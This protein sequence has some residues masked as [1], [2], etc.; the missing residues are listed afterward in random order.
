MKKVFLNNLGLS[1]SVRIKV[2]NSFKSRLFQIKNLDKIPTYETKPEPTIEPSTEPEIGTKATKAE[3]K[4]KT[5]SLKLRENFLNGIKNEEK[6]IN[7]HIFKEYFGYES[8]SFLVKD[9]HESHQNKND[10]VVKYLNE[11]LIDLRNN[12]STIEIPEN[13]NPKKVVCIVEKILDFNKQ[14]KGEGLRGMLAY[15]PSDFDRKHIKI[16]TPKQMIQR[17]SI[18]LA[19]V[20]AGN[21]SEKLLNEIRQIIYSL[22]R[23]K[24]ITKKIIWSIIRYFTQK[25]LYF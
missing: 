7:E 17:L 24:E 5:S 14:Q 9:L 11:S 2:L 19:Q 10:M 12:T 23:T 20:K 13:E 8:P 18:A 25:F 4:C 21:T 16:L 3:T 1:F 15:R 6:N 22:Y